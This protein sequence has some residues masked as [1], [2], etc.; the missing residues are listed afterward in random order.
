M[1]NCCI[2]RKKKR[3]ANIQNPIS[4]HD[5]SSDDSEDEFFDCGTEEEGAKRIKHSLWNKPIGRLC[6]HSNSL[7]LLGTGEAM[8]IPITQEPVPKTEDQLEEDTDVLLK[9]GSD[10]HGSELRA[11]MMSASLLSDMESFKAANPNSI[12][13]DFIRWYSPRD[14]IEEEELDKWGQKKGHLSTRMLISDNT[15]LVMWQSSKPVPAHRQKRLFDDTREAEKVLHFLDSRYA[16]S[17]AKLLLPVL[18]QNGLYRV[19]E[20]I[21]EVRPIMPDLIIVLKHITKTIERLSRGQLPVHK[22]EGL[23]QEITT[24][25]VLIS[26]INSLLF[27]FNPSGTIND[28]IN[29]FV[30]NL[31]SGKEV[32]IEGCA[33]SFIGCRLRHMFSEAQH[34]SKVLADLV[35]DHEPFNLQNQKSVFPPATKREFVLK[36]GAV[37]PASYSTKSDQM[38]RAIFGKNEFRLVGAFSEDVTFN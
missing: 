10:A 23:I 16:R 2:E 35:D 13:E 22:Y 6:K 5:T 20:E 33:Q 8:Y 12:L 1:L 28:R 37:R 38:L 32:A 30:I 24:Q 7:K 14:W 26:Q 4:E 3:E 19:F 9:L 27:K 17:I 29:D 31:V 36:V 21:Q 11:R 18:M 15:W 34:A 25:E